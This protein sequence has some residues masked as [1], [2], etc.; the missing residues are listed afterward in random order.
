VSWSS[1]LVNLSFVVSGNMPITGGA[2]VGKTQRSNLSLHSLKTPRETR[3]IHQRSRFP[4]FSSQ[5][6]QID[7]TDLVILEFDVDDSA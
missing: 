4:G 3:E 6:F 2:G 1:V 5:V 7:H